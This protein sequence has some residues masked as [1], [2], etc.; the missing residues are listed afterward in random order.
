MSPPTG[1]PRERQWEEEEARRGI[2]SIKEGPFKRAQGLPGQV[3]GSGS[4][5]SE[6]TGL[7]NPRHSGSAV[8]AAVGESSPHYKPTVVVSRANHG[9]QALAIA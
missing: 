8:K 1:Q 5:S 9:D 2:R 3:S 6:A 4:G 7:M